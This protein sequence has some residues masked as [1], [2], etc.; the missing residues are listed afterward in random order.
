MSQLVS[1]IIP[2]FNRAHSLPRAIDSALAQGQDIEIL[3]ADDGS[4]D[5]T[6]RIVE[7][8]YG[9]D[10]Q[11]RYLYQSNQGVAAAR[12]LCLREVKGDYV[13]FLDSDDVWLPG[14]LSLQLAC[15]EA[16]PAAGIVWS[17]MEAV[18]V[19]GQTVHPRYLGMMYQG[20]RR[21]QRFED[22]FPRKLSL[23]R[24]NGE[25]TVYSGD[26]FSDMVLGNLVHTPTVLM[27][28]ERAERVGEFG[29][30]FR[31]AGEDYDYHLRSCREGE[32]AFVDAVTIR[33]Q[34]GASDAITRPELSLEMAKAYLTTVHETLVRDRHRIK[35]PEAVVNQS[36]AGAYAWAARAALDGGSAKEAKRYYLASLKLRPLHW[37][38]LK[39]YM[40]ASLPAAVRQLLRRSVRATRVWTSRAKVH[41]GEALLLAGP[42]APILSGE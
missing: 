7:E 25:V 22:L 1:V 16:V 17:D 34:I 9:H 42:L 32:V 37:D 11:V 31:R 41:A 8:R 2:T 19:T 23:Q 27:R 10:P 13:A 26:I 29:T 5:E 20:Y 6:R 36:L 38:S 24:S 35:L 21:F 4:T 18:D 40:V 12:N 33:Y 3:V 39:F 30:E 28:R 14:K 15:L